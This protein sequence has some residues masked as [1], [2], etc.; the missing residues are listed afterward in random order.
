MDK[1]FEDQVQELN[2]VWHRIFKTARY[3]ELNETFDFIDGLSTTEISVISMVAYNKEIVLKDIINE[4][5][6]P[7]S[8]LTS[9]I[10]RLEKRGFLKRVINPND[11]RCYCLELTKQGM[12][13]EKQHQE[14]ETAIF[15]TLLKALDTPE[16]RDS[17]IKLV[18]EIIENLEND[19]SNTKGT[20]SL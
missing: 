10:D 1:I 19:K 3:R 13:L 2:K 15:S 12:Q 16:K 11:R 17:L 14:S 7:K 4:L 8:T 20:A 6:L 9:M 5:Q 18:T